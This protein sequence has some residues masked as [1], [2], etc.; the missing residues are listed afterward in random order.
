MFIL[1]ELERLPDTDRNH[2]CRGNTA[3]LDFFKAVGLSL[4]KE[5]QQHS[6]AYLK[7]T[8]DFHVFEDNS[9]ITSAFAEE[10]PPKAP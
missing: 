8:G 5:F 6:G 10:M 4:N 2:F 7:K 3:L 9:Q 1:R